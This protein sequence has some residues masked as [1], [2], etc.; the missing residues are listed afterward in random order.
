VYNWRNLITIVAKS[1]KCW[2]VC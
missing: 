2:I 1:F